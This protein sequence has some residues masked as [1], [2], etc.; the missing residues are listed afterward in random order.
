VCGDTFDGE[1][2]SKEAWE[3]VLE[4][5]LQKLQSAAQSLSASAVA[6]ILV[7][8]LLFALLAE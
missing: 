6:A 3:L 8:I 2:C 5:K 1:D 4:A 7:L